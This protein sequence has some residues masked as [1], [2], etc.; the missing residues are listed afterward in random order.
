V[1]GGLGGPFVDIDG[2][3]AAA[4]AVGFPVMVK[5]SGGGGGIGMAIAHAPGELAG[6]LA[7]VQGRARQAF[8]SDDVFVERYFPTA[9]HIEVQ[10]LGLADG[11]VVTL[12]DR[13]CSAQRRYQKLVEESPAPYLP[14]SLRSELWDAARRISERVGYTNAGTVE[15]LV[16]GDDFVFLEVNARLQVEHPVTEM[17]TGIDL[18]EEQLRVASGEQAGF[19]PASVTSEGHAIELRVYAEDPLRFLPSPGQ[20][21]R[22]QEPTGEGVRVDA[23]YQAGNTVTPYYDPLLAKVCVWGEDRA[24]A[25]KLALKAVSAFE[26]EGPRT[27]LEFLRELVGSP[28]FVDAAY[29]TTIVRKLR[30]QY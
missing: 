30:P 11:T 20:I 1:S 2:A 18:V 9:R 14:T 28:E 16:S 8:G 12:G 7:Q 4:A 10:V 15:F 25:T 29:D 24:L 5:A 26:V 27:N 13:D 23:G 6:V 3:R 22:W 21:T 19:D 17:V